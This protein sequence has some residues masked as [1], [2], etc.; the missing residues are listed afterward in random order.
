MP[1]G[2]FFL[3]QKNK[4]SVGETVEIVKPSGEN[5]TAV[6]ESISDLDGREQESAPHARQELSVKLSRRPE[7][8]DIL[9]K[10]GV[11]V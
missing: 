3:E 8:Y 2:R 9:R 10:K 5:L 1:E 7:K 11:S 4:F 6:V